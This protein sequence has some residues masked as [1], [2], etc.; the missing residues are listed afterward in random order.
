MQKDKSAITSLNISEIE[1]VIKQYGLPSWRAKQLYSWLHAKGATSFEEMSDLPR[2]FREKLAQTHRIESVSPAAVQTAADGT[3]K[4]LF[5]LWDENEVESVVMRYNH[6]ISVCVSSQAGCR[7]G[8]DFCASA[9]LGLGRNLSAGEMLAQVYAAAALQ[10]ERVGHVVLMGI[11]EPL[12]NYEQVLK[13]IRMLS[14]EAGYGMSARNISLSTCGVVP[15]IRRLA[16]EGLGL[17]LSVSLHAAN[18]PLRSRLMPVNN[19][20]PLD[21]L[22]DECLN[23]QNETKRRISFE[24]ALMQGV[25]DSKNDANTLAG[26]L[27]SRNFSPR[28]HL[29]LIGVNSVAGGKYTQSSAEQTHAFCEILKSRGINVTLRRRLGDDIDA[30]CGQLRAKKAAEKQRTKAKI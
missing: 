15:G 10:A 20:W 16:K 9:P 7:M 4:L 18:D 14:D 22:M 26:L 2:S 30:A 29:N 5:S 6:G 3:K 13:F 1:Q 12:D 21:V 17:T 24:Y 25:N 19:S 11:G 8:C 23:Y 28:P 27:R